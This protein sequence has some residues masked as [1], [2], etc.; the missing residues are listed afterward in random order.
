M[1]AS[2]FAELKLFLSGYFHEDWE[3]DGCEPDEIIFLFMKSQPSSA[4][5]DRLVS[6]IARFLDAGKCEAS[7][8]CRLLEEL[9]CY[10]LP[11]ADG[12]NA[13]EWLEHVVELLKNGLRRSVPN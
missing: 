11:S 7:L 13:R 3:L 8:E 2:D 1:T 4:E 9:G 12:V 10:Y 5:V 6:Q